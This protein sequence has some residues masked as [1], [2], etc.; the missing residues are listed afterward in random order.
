MKDLL[1]VIDMQNVYGPKEEWACPSFFH[2]CQQIRRLLDAPQCG[3]AYDVVFTAFE[4]SKDPVGCWHNYNEAYRSINEDA[5]LGQITEELRPYLDRWP[6][7]RKSTYSSLAIPELAAMLPQYE[8]ILLTGVVAECCVV[9]TAL[10]LI[11]AGARVCYLT[12][13]VSGQSEEN[14]RA[15]QRL[16][17]GFAPIHADVCTVEMYLKTLC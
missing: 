1:L 11:D 6:L 15:M 10:A 7:Y 13:G 5:R 16:L 17:E 2:A 12:D 3:E 9:A 8:R 4:A 14:E